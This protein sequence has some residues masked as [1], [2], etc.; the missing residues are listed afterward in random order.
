MR[1]FLCCIWFCALSLLTTAHAAEFL[2][3]RIISFNA[4]ICTAP[5]VKAGQLERFRFD[6]AR[7]EH[8][9]RVADLIETLN[10][11]I[12]NLAEVTSKEA[13]DLIVGELHEKGLTQYTGYHVDS[14]DSFTGM[15]V[16]LVT[17]YPPDVIG[18]LPI[19]TI[20]SAEGDPTWSQAFSFVE[21]D[22][23][24]VNSGTSLGRNSLYFITVNGWKLGFLGLHLKSNPEDAYSNA[25]RTA[26][27]ALAQR[28]CRGEIVRRGYLPVVLGDLND[29]D[30]DV[31]DA[32]DTRSPATNVLAS[33]KD[34]DPARPGPELINSAMFVKR[35]S[36]RYSSHWDWNE[37]GAHDPQDVY[38]MIDH[39]LLPKE[40]Q[41]F[42]KRVFICHS[43]D[44]E[45][46]D[47]YPVVVDLELPA[48]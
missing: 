10:P 37:N 35:V 44:L 36:D 7:R 28:V 20:Y 31:E 48:K 43:T 23:S 38:T 30:P 42:V 14:N 33:I 9:K 24:T 16:S 3:L 25:R 46:S 39:V 11:D 34:F 2:P 15:D 13:V 21:K 6:Y 8:C 47:H 18:G 45:T 40:F 4:E 22:G 26:E 41:P 27:A 5:G 19:R 32:D 17:K 29:Y 12:L 1:W